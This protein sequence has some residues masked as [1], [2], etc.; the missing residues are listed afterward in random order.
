MGISENDI[1]SLL[2]DIERGKVKLT[3]DEDPQEQIKGDILFRT[4]NGWTFEVSNWCGEFAGIVEVVTPDGSVLDTEFLEHHMSRVHD[5]FPSADV[6]EHAWGMKAVECGFIYVA[7]SKPGRLQNAKAGDIIA[8]PDD[9]PPWIVLY[10]RLKDVLVARWPGTLW[11]AQV[12]KRLE[13][14]DHRGNYIRCISVK[15]IREMDTHLLFGPNGKDVETVLKY[16][17]NI[18]RA[19]ALNLSKNRH[20]NAKA[21]QSAGWHRWQEKV[22]GEDNTPDR[23]MSGVVKGAN[24]LNSPVGHGLSL[25]H[26]GVWDAAKRIDGEAAFEEN[27]EEMW[28]I[29]PW[30]GAGSVMLDTVWAMGAPELF[31]ED[32]REVLLQAW[33][34]RGG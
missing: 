5:Y 8:N 13:P 11:L 10:P 7:D 30:A 9:G 16:A 17:L 15:F 22:K 23:D 24:N 27:E 32:E 1:L 18:N 14:Q 29:E 33:N 34:R 26:R 3:P 6:A 4:E 28:L 25:A 21:L 2:K 19:Q 20:E 31:D 12:I